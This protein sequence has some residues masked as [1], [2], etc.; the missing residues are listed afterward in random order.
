MPSIILGL[1]ALLLGAA[2][3]S[4]Y[5]P[6][7]G[8]G[9]NDGGSFSGASENSNNG[10][11]LE[12][13]EQAQYRPGGSSDYEYDYDNSITGDSSGA[14]G[15]NQEQQFGGSQN[16]GDQDQYG[17]QNGG[18]SF[19]IAGSTGNVGVGINGDLDNPSVD[20]SNEQ[21]YDQDGESQSGSGSPDSDGFAGNV[22]S[23]IG[24][25]E[26][27]SLQT[28]AGSEDSVG[29]PS[30]TE[31]S[32]NTNQNKDD[33]SVWSLAESIPGVAG[34]DY[35]ILT[36]VPE[37]SF[38]CDGLVDGGYYADPEAECQSFHVCA[39]DGNGGLRKFSFM[40][41]NGTIFN[42]Q[43][44]VCDWWFNV[45]C[46]LTEELYSINVENAAERDANIGAGSIDNESV[47]T[48]DKDKNSQIFLRKGDDQSQSFS[49]GEN[50]D[51]K[52][53]TRGEDENSPSFSSGEDDTSKSFSNGQEAQTQSFSS[54]E[55]DT[56]KSFSNGQEAQNRNSEQNSV[57][58]VDIKKQPSTN[59]E[60]NA[61]SS[62]RK[63]NSRNQ[64]DAKNSGTKHGRG[65]NK[66]PTKLNSQK[67]E[68]RNRNN[69][70]KGGYIAP[71]GSKPNGQ[72]SNFNGGKPNDNFQLIQD[73]NT[74]GNGNNAGNANLAENNNLSGYGN[75]S[76]NGN[77]NG[78]GNTG[79]NG[80]TSENGNIG[81]NGN[82]SGNG[83]TVGNGRP[84]GGSGQ[85]LPLDIGY[86]APGGQILGS[87]NGF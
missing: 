24:N 61:N 23:G 33:K 7:G 54:G 16:N 86:G 76:G 63:S 38:L 13:Q 8:F 68:P 42:Q 10:D 17:N 87:Y 52:S 20:Q 50:D 18:N 78:N 69:V 75:N 81:G 32:S 15:G 6:G 36:N 11:Y 51:S 62:F 56:S 48:G 77:T 58:S 73:G 40:C 19:A 80:N 5:R 29:N 71:G 60:S 45:D 43:V 47:N 22:G 59:P 12:Y 85:I 57:L 4:Q 21:D 64:V 31:T 30:K 79:G 41:P 74:A 65:G 49:R 55:D 1:S 9:G 82:T 67:F 27:N 46:S 14:F 53:I 25:N 70:Q 26:A 35:P 3:Q 44:L 34:D 2:G 28:P 72:H 66:R 83:N 39:S 37:T 84:A